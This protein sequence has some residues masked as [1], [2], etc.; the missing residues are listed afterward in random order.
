[1]SK[2]MYCG[3]C[4]QKGRQ[5][6]TGKS[7]ICKVCA[8]RVQRKAAREAGKTII[9]E[10]TRKLRAERELD[11]YSIESVSLTPGTVSRRR[12]DVTAGV[13]VTIVSGGLPSLGKRRS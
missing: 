13:R 11:R 3:I 5:V 8:G 2:P 7:R 9:E 6:K 10:V 1:V 4:L 12:E